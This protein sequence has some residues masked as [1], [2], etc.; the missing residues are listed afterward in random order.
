MAAVTQI[1]TVT[2]AP[3]AKAVK[4]QFAVLLVAGKGK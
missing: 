1:I 3:A 2:A 4:V